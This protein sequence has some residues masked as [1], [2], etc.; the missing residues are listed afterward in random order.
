MKITFVPCVCDRVCV[1]VYVG[2]V[3]GEQVGAADGLSMCVNVMCVCEV[4]V[5]LMCIVCNMK[6]HMKYTCLSIVRDCSA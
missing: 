4:R 6:I 5:V 1:P 2:S 3:L